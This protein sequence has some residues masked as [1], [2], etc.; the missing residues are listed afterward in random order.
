MALVPAYNEAE[1]IVNVIQSLHN[2]KPDWDILVIN[3]ASSDDTS[4]LAR[5]TGLCKVVDLPYNMGIGGGIQTG[6]KYALKNQ[7]DFAF[8]F[9]GDGQ[10][11]AEEIEKILLPIMK[12]QADMVIGSRFLE[13]NDGFQ[14]SFSR[15]FGIKIFS[16][17]TRLLIG[18]R[19]LDCTSG[20]RAYNR[21]AFGFL[22]KYYPVDYP[23][24]E[25]IILL[26]HNGFAVREVPTRMQHRKWG[27]STITFFNSPYYMIKVILGMLMTKMRRKVDV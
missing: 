12:K 15:R 20:F 27:R 3:D 18:Q 17:L 9:D 10:H 16:L 1:N 23:E 6:F 22:A 13:K 8:Q 2:Y 7:Y 5:D 21:K 4:D 24:P 14:S 26:G 25:A 19:I 11:L